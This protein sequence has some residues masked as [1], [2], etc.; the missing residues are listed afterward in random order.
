M[1]QQTANTKRLIKSGVAAWLLLCLTTTVSAQWLSSATNNADYNDLNNWTSGTINDQFVP[2]SGSTYDWTANYKVTVSGTRELPGNFVYN[3]AD[4]VEFTLEPINGSVWKFSSASPKIQVLMGPYNT[5]KN[6]TFGAASRTFALDLAGKDLTF[7]ID[8]LIRAGAAVDKPEQWQISGNRDNFNNYVELLN[9]KNL[10]KTGVGKL[11][12]YKASAV[13]GDVNVSGGWLDV[14]AA[15]TGAKNINVTNQGV[16][17]ELLASS[18]ADLLDAATKIN[19]Y[20]GGFNLAASNSQNVGDMTL[21]GGHALLGNTT[22][23][24]ATKTLTLHSLDRK[25]FATL[26]LAGYGYGA[27]VVGIGNGNNFIKVTNDDNLTAALVGGGG[28]AGSTTISIIPWA[29]S[30]MSG[31]N[32]LGNR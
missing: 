8:T 14:N 2:V 6:F 18:P 27:T 10:N 30:M 19:L 20:S 4:N 31:D 16:F 29:G 7:E 1:K 3:N 26:T 28:A 17:F 13:S 12:L 22:N 24:A 5:S 32:E 25:N 11:R 21:Y 9:V 23:A 15:I